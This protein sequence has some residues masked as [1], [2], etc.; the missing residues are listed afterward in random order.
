MSDDFNMSLLD[1]K[2]NEKIQK[3]VNIMFGHSMVP[4]INKPTRVAK[5][6]GTAIDHIFIN[7][8]T[9]TTFKTGVIR[10]DIL[11]YFPKC[12]VANYNIHINETNDRC[13]FRW[14]PFDISLD[15]FKYKLHTVSTNPSDTN[16]TYENFIE[17]FGSFY[18][19]SFPKTKIKAT[20]Q[21]YSFS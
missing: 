12:F 15:N 17:I 14:D 19:E 3:F 9:A 18:G 1:F 10:S 16:N 2:Q 7:S 6:N 11:D 4:I 21:N 20:S 5:K 8:I 13:I